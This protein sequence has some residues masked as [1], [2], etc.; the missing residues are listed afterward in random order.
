MVTTNNKIPVSRDRKATLFAFAPAVLTAAAPTYLPIDAGLV[1]PLLGL[2]SLTVVFGLAVLWRQSEAGRQIL[3]AQ[4]PGTAANQAAPLILRRPVR[5]EGPASLLRDLAR[6]AGEQDGVGT[7]ASTVFGPRLALVHQVPPARFPEPSL[8][9]SMRRPSA[10]EAGR[11]RLVLQAFEADRIELHLQPIVSLPHTQDPL[12]RGPGPAASRGRDPARARRSS[13][14]SLNVRA[15][16][17]L[18]TGGS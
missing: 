2:L 15:A 12:L 6:T 11:V 5:A 9:P 3:S 16:H 17:R 14:P 10:E 13:C 18:S 7:G 8:L 4:L 1:M